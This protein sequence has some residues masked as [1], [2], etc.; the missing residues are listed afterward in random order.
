MARGLSEEGYVVER[1][2]D[3]GAGWWRLQG[4]TWDLVLLDWWLP[5]EDG[6]Q[7]LRRETRTEFPNADMADSRAAIGRMFRRD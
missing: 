2:A 6:V 4:E 1:A 7:L 3:G 5:V